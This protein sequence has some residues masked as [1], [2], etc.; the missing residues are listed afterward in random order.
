MANTISDIRSLFLD[1]PVTARP[2]TMT[3]S[4][5]ALLKNAVRVP[6]QDLWITQDVL[7]DD[8]R[9]AFSRIKDL[10]FGGVVINVDFENYLE[11]EQR[12]ATFVQGFRVCRELGL[13]VWIYDELGYPSGA[14][15][16]LVLRDHP[17][18]EAEVICR[19]ES[20]VP[21]GKVEIR[22]PTSW[23]YAVKSTVRCD[24]DVLDITEHIGEDGFLRWDA[25][26]PCTIERY[27]VRSGFEG[28]HAE[29][30][31]HAVRRYVNVMNPDAIKRFYDVTYQAYID[32]LGDELD[33]VEAFFTDEPSFMAIYH[34]ELPERY[35]EIIPVVDKPVKDFDRL[36]Q[37]PWRKGLQDDF[38]ARWH[39]DLLPVLP[40]LFGGMELADLR[41]RH[42]FYQLISELYAEAYFKGLQEPL[43]A[44]GLPLSGHVL[45][46]ERL[47]D[48]VACQGNI[49]GLLKEMDK[50]GI[51][52]LTATPNNLIS[53]KSLL[54]C[55]YG[56]S[57]AHVTGKNDIL[58]ETFDWEEQNDGLTTT[59]EQRRGS[60][61]MQSALGITTFASY[62]RWKDFD[63][64]DVHKLLDTV[65]RIYP[66]VRFGTHV[67][68]VAVLYPIRTAWAYYLPTTATIDQ[69]VQPEELASL[70]RQLLEITAMLV[71]NQIDF[72]FADS[73]SLMNTEAQN[74]IFHIAEESYQHLVVPPNA[75]LCPKDIETVRRLAESGVSITAF[76]PLSKMRLPNV[77]DTRLP[78][79]SG[80]SPA[81]VLTDLA[82]RFPETVKV[83]DLGENW[84]SFIEENIDRD[85]VISGDTDSIAV[86]QS[87]LDDGDIFLLVNASESPAKLSI[88]LTNA[89]AAEIWNPIDG[90]TNAFSSEIEIEGY[91]AIIIAARD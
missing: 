84:L 69:M 9:A 83:C 20:K 3:H 25:P 59:L 72:D 56:S 55:K 8:L 58:S 26:S 35:R 10:G 73:R 57:S 13:R 7:A 45:A 80:E 36:P 85:I 67:A 16:G 46:E 29:L 64:G 6:T 21:A 31:V 42:D 33:A 79:E 41:V 37:I 77:A 19:S 54:V 2:I 82:D 48:H 81:E 34:C 4:V 50:P 22:P 60:L 44:H 86:R 5:D 30:N 27:D 51:D 88:Q 47:V 65:S 52:M 14:A 68:P 62:F 18:F 91:G 49:M 24:G 23:W 39:Y 89:K 63:R 76:S 70:D 53:T 74:G 12:W 17:E 61:A 15:G 40:S 71:C 28:T 1:P 78:E 43:R 90:S 11:D 87:R 38:K 32:H 66:A 75:V